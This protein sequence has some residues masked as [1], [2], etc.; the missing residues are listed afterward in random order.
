MDVV[1][2]HFYQCTET[3]QRHDRDVSIFQMHVRR[4]TRLIVLSTVR[5]DIQELSPICQRN[6]VADRKFDGQFQISTEIRCLLVT[7][8]PPNFDGCLPFV[9]VG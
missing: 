3:S 8:Q 6:S 1:E 2:R 5:A 9:D 7:E 4:G